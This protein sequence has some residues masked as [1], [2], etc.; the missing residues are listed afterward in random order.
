MNRLSVR[1]LA[2][3][4][5]VAVVGAVVG[6]AVVRL[7]VPELYDQHVHGMAGHMEGRMPLRDAAVDAMN[8]ALLIGVL[9]GIATAVAVGAYGSARIMRPLRAVS[10]ATHR[11]AE[12]DYDHRIAPPREQELAAVAEDVNAL[13]TRLAETEAR[14]V[15]LLAEVAHEMRTPLTILDGYVEGMV[16]GVFAPT[17]EVLTECSGELRR[18]RRL[19]EDLRALSQAEE[20]RFDLRPAEVD[21][22]EI[23][24]RATE[25][26]RPQFQDAGVEL[27]VDAPMALPVRGD[28]DRLAQVVT[29][30]LGNALAA[31]GAGG[32]VR[33]T[34]GATGERG[35]VTVRDDG[36]G[37]AAED[38]D[39]IFERFYRVPTDERRHGT[40][41]GL[42]IARGIARAHGGDLRAAS[43]GRGHGASFTLSVPLRPRSRRV[44]PEGRSVRR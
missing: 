43:P 1:L 8:A 17:P 14:R 20:G 36:V 6:Y 12:G 24:A 31:T 16:D 39:R 10:R 35:V 33:V 18:L 42:T 41:I 2:S 5:L 27:R 34:A 13:A 38:V 15:R 19:S 29:N 4:A 30:L 21:L 9:A 7:L 26:L 32:H 11:M 3:H 44:R 37:L 22:A 25:R 28:P 23:A 40:G